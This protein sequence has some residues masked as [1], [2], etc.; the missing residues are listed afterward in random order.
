MLDDGGGALGGDIVC[1]AL[2]AGPHALY[3]AG[4]R[5]QH[6]GTQQLIIIPVKSGRYSGGMCL[7]P[8][9]PRCISYIYYVYYG[10]ILYTFRNPCKD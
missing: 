7:T 3:V 9:V 6:P 1:G 4:Q 5:H 2:L 8:S 10:V